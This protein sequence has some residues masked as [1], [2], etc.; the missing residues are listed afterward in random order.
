MKTTRISQVNVEAGRVACLPA[1]NLHD[2]TRRMSLLFAMAFALLLLLSA[3]FQSKAQSIVP[4]YIPLNAEQL[5]QLVAPIALDPDPLVAQILIGATFPDQVTDAN[6]WVLSNA[7]L[8]SDQRATR[9]N[10]MAWD[11]SV[12][13]LVIFPLVLD[14]MAKNNAWTVQLGN[15][16]YNQPDDVMSA[17]Q[18]LRQ[19][20]M[21]ARVLVT[22]PQE[23]VIVTEDVIEIQPADPNVVFVANYNPWA[24]WGSLF[25]AYP[26]FVAEPAPAGLVVA[27]GVSFDPAVAVSLDANFGFSFGG[28]DPGFGGG[29]V[30]YNNNVYNSNSRSVADRGHFGGHDCRAFEHGGRGVPAGFHPGRGGFGGRDP[31]ARPMPGRIA[32]RELNRQPNFNSHSNQVSRNSS[33]T[34]SNQVGRNFGSTRSNQVSRNYGNN[35]GR[36]SSGAHTTTVSQPTQMGRQRSAN[37]NSSTNRPQVRNMPSTHTGGLSHN[38]VASHTA[39]ANH[40]VASNRTPNPSANHAMPSSRTT[41]PSATHTQASNRP[42]SQGNM[43]RPT[44]RPAS[45][46]NAMAANRPASR[47]SAGGNSF[48][49][50]MNRPAAN[51]A[52]ANRP[53]A[54]PASMSKPA[55][56]GSSFGH[57]R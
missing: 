17:I 53:M 9:A 5:D 20:A 1:R 55:G 30:T 7:S 18:A 43:N 47:P 45:A 57:K 28:W 33:S 50:S 2:S 54:R 29:A 36:L 51:N 34:R 4:E 13:G 31:I 52:A 23:R 48:G 12:K 39:P 38:N 8:S 14:S 44:P 24:V 10:S 3:Q 37:R 21:T 15:A 11:P 40:S 42:M 41:S 49:Q 46:T 27:D 32:G 19:Q 25:A 6:N 16:Y 35:A 22:V 26:G 56:G